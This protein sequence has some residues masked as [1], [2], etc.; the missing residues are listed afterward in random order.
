MS[1]TP[2]VAYTQFGNYV[3][4]GGWEAVHDDDGVS[5]YQGVQDANGQVVALV[6]ARSPNIFDEKLETDTNARLIA[7]APELLALLKRYRD[8]TP[9]GYQPHM[10]VYEADT[11]IDKI[12]GK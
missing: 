5:Q 2:W 9:I 4:T 6:V 10:I 3:S 11:L 8:E 1:N 7:A 12:E